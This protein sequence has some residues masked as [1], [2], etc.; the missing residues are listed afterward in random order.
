MPFLLTILFIRT[1]NIK[2]CE[3][4]SKRSK[5]Q[6]MNSDS[7]IFLPVYGFATIVFKI[8]KLP[9]QES[10]H[11]K[12]LHTTRPIWARLWHVPDFHDSVSSESDLDFRF[13]PNLIWTCNIRFQIRSSSGSLQILLKFYVKLL[14]TWNLDL[15][16]KFQVKFGWDRKIVS[17]SPRISME[18]FEIPMKP[19]TENSGS[20][21]IWT[22]PE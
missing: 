16:P 1:W 10:S 9:S 17:G 6:R 3:R 4:T 12:W 13:D 8:F 18:P 2:C 20:S 11:K 5:M 15:K 7:T 21:E 19:E 14:L 22:R